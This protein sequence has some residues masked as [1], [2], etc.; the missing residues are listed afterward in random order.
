[1]GPL[2]DAD[3]SSSRGLGSEAGAAVSS[4]LPFVNGAI[5]SGATAAAAA[6]PAGG[7]AL[8]HSERKRLMKAKDRVAKLWADVERA[9]EQMRLLDEEMAEAGADAG[10]AREVHGKRAALEA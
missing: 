7:G 3:L 4:S 10:R 2:S 1:M 8:S 5:D 9:E 6:S